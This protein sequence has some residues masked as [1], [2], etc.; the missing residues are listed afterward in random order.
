MSK[1]ESGAERRERLEAIKKAQKA[2]ER[3]RTMLTAAIGLGVGVLIIGGT[4]TAIVV[5]QGSKAENQPFSSFGVPAVEAGCSDAQSKPGSG[6]TVHVTKPVQYDTIPA[7]SGEHNPQWVGYPASAVRNFFTVEDTPEIENLVHNLEHGYT[8]A[9]YLPTLPQSE[10]D[11]LQGLSE[12]VS[13]DTDTY[14][15]IVAPWDTS[16]GEFPDGK[17]VGFSH[18]GAEQASI[19]LCA[20]V[21]GE[22]VDEFVSAH[23][24]TDAPE[25]NAA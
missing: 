13:S 25:P 15:F 8:I 24:I 4:V 20:Q 3:K 2:E 16:R 1:R 10:I 19:Q 12:K 21:S 22:A 5:Q 11:T 17:S 9:W 14:K 23:P 7:S 18:W 6:S